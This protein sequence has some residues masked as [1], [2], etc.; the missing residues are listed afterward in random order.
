MKRTHGTDS[1]RIPGL[2]ATQADGL[3][4]GC[5]A[6]CATQRG[7]TLAVFTL[8]VCVTHQPKR[9]CLDHRDGSSN[10]THT[11]QD[12]V[13]NAAVDHWV[14]RV[15]HGSS[16]ASTPFSA[17]GIRSLVGSNLTIPHRGG[18]PSDQ[19]PTVVLL[20]CGFLRA[21]ARPQPLRH[22]DAGAAET[23]ALQKQIGV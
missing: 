5:R 9:A 13:S 22:Y 4:R 7:R 11:L 18:N 19:Q 1:R 6:P 20:V 2:N 23:P 17:L 12:R 16:P 10:A 14:G 3:A 8:T 21:L 15:F